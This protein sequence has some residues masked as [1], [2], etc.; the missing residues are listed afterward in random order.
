MTLAAGGRRSLA[1]WLPNTLHVMS[2]QTDDTICAIATAPGGAARGMVRVSG[3]AAVAIAKRLFEPTDRQPVDA[4]RQATALS[5]RVRIDFDSYRR[6]LPC[7]LFVWPTHRSYTREPVVELHTI[8][9]P[10]LLEAVLAAVCRAGARLAE[11]GEFTLRAF[12]AGRID[13]TQAEAVLGVIDAGG[14]QDLDAALAQLAGGLAEPL[15]HL[16]EELLQLLAEVE[17]GLDFVED[18]IE[19]VSSPELL[20]RLQSASEL[21]EDVAQQMNSRH[22]AG[23]ATQIA[24]VGPANVGKSSL[25]NAIVAR[26]GCGSRLGANRATPALVSPQRGTTR[27]Y[28][29]AAISVG[30]VRCQLIDTAGITSIPSETPLKTTSIDGAAQSL[31]AERREQATIRAYCVEA[32]GAAD[33]CRQLK[34]ESRIGARRGDIVVL[35]KADLTPDADQ[36]AKERHAVPTILTSSRTGQGLDQL[37]ALFR[38]QLMR[39]DFAECGQI[40]S[41]TADRCRESVRLAQKSLDLAMEIV[42]SG[43]GNELLALELRAALAEL[44]KVVGTVYTDDLLDR[45]FGTFCIGK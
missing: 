38:V 1:D 17:A 41:A 33:G 9:S 31:A 4:L 44:G 19:F 25:F 12:L 36:H 39:T 30:G 11:P 37:A 18:D 35:T 42:R 32:K 43:G 27:D 40:V 21:L 15:Q 2:L 34:D 20:E 6:D 29:V 3:P 10:P 24:L 5:G 45:I 13:L 7:E 26:Y 28:L 16:R 8:G 23:E 22:V 14:R